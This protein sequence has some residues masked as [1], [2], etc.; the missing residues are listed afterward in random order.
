M[1]KIFSSFLCKSHFPFLSPSILS[2]PTSSSHHFCRISLNSKPIS[3]F[4]SGFFA[5]RKMGQNQLSCKPFHN[6]HLIR[7]QSRGNG[8][9]G[10]SGSGG[11]SSGGRNEGEGGENSRSLLSWYLMLLEKYPVY[12]KA[13]TSAL[14]TLIGDLVCQLLIEK[15]SVLDS[16]R[17]FLF[18]LLG[19]V[20]VGPT[21]HFWYLKLSNLVTQPGGSGALLRLLLDQFLFSPLFIGF[22]MSTIVTLEGRPS[23]VVPRLRQEWF[24][25]I[26]A[27]WQLWI[28][29][30]FLNFLYV[31]QQFQVLAANFIALA[32]NVILSYKAHRVLVHS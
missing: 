5:V 21:L 14:L 20:L 23:E 30:Q 25:T 7:A 31:P 1:A 28:P 6:G 11:G 12:T 22:F 24:S 15:V 8:G 10:G 13:L 32:W 29:F 26:L 27:N 3:G 17:T 19:L 16:K 4:G 18:T 9:I 2:K